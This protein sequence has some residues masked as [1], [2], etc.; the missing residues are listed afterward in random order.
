MVQVTML[1]A[2]ITIPS[3]HMTATLIVYASK[4]KQNI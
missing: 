4:H 3:E 2:T 1:S